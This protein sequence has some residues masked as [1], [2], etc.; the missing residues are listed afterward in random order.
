MTLLFLWA[1]PAGR[2]PAADRARSL[3]L[4]ACVLAPGRPHADGQQ[5]RALRGAAGRA[6]AAVRR[7]GGDAPARGTPGARSG[8]SRA[9]LA[10]ALLGIA[11]RVGRCGARCAKRER[12]RATNRRAPPTTRPCSRFLARVQ[13]PPAPLVRV[14][15]PLTRSHWEAALLAPTVSLARGWEKQLEERYDGVL[16]EPGLTAAGYER[17]LH[18]QAVALRRAARH[19]ARSLERPGGPADPRRA[20][21]PARGLREQALDGLRGARP[22]AAAGR[23]RAADRARATTPSRCAR[24]GRAGFSCACTT[25]ASGRSPPAPAASRGARGLDLRAV[26][27]RPGAT[28]GRGALLARPGSARVSGCEAASAGWARARRGRC[29]P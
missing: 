19:A 9:V 20:A 4:L 3:Y 28:A 7:C 22:D 21:V 23:P 1:L 25:P 8:R 26:A 15:V 16:L 11:R 14:E 5:H 18:E 17:W 12:S 27:D 29:S 6:A 2:A 13:A 10:L 24:A